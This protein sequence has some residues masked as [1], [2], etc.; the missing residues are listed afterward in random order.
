[1]NR[2]LSCMAAGLWSASNE[3]ESVIEFA[4]RIWNG[5]GAVVCFGLWQRARV[6]PTG[7][8]R[9]WFGRGFPAR[10]FLGLGRRLLPLRFGWCFG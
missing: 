6:G 5:I 4:I 2:F 10:C 1:M 7:V 8:E 3:D 9:R